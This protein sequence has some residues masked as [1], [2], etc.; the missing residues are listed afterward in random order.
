MIESAH[1]Y[2]SFFSETEVLLAEVE[3]WLRS[4]VIECPESDTLELSANGL[5][6]NNADT[7]MTSY[8]RMIEITRTLEGILDKIRHNDIAYDGHINSLVEATAALKEFI[9]GAS[10]KSN[11]SNLTNK[12]NGIE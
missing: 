9:G 10:D 6:L 11:Q 2:E 8:L 5:E 4:V 7:V 12:Q 1:F 3:Q